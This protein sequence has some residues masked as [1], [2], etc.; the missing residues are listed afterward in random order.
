MVQSVSAESWVTY[1]EGLDPLLVTSDSTH[2]RSINFRR[3]HFHSKPTRCFR[4][5]L[6]AITAT[7]ACKV[8][9]FSLHPGKFNTY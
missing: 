5:G 6:L 7:N 1:V 9:Q 4:I 3:C 2:Q 8:E